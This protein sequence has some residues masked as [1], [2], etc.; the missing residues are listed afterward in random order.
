MAFSARVP[1]GLTIA[2]VGLVFDWL[3]PLGLAT[4]MCQLVIVWSICPW[5]TRREILAVAVSCSTFI[6]VGLWLSP[7][8]SFPVWISAINRTLV[9]VIL[10]LLVRSVL[11]QRSVEEAHRKAES[12]LDEASA[13]LRVLSGLLP[14]C[15]GCKKIRNVEGAWEPLESYIR[16]HSQADFTHGLCDECFDRLYPDYNV[17]SSKREDVG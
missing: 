14:I 3:T 4:W 7:C 2:A 12:E 8:G 9:V 6:L 1:I 17:K 10:W 13:R 16:D 11:E 15:A 5:A